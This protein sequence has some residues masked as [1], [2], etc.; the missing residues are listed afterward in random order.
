M[1]FIDLLDQTKR[2]MGYRSSRLPLEQMTGEEY[3]VINHYLDHY[4]E[5]T[6]E[7]QLESAPK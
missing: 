7:P 3:M 5:R 1:G 6:L 4:L 2:A